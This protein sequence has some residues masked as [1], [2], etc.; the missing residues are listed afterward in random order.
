MKKLVS[1]L[2]AL[3]MLFSL[4]LASAEEYAPYEGHV[5]NYLQPAGWATLTEEYVLMQV[6]TMTDWVYSLSADAGDTTL[7]QV[8]EVSQPLEEGTVQSTAES[9]LEGVSNSYSGIEYTRE[10]KNI[11]DIFTITYTITYSG[12]FFGGVIASSTSGAINIMFI[13]TALSQDDILAQLYTIRD[14]I[15]VK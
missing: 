14:S 11:G 6:S 8:E 12:L 7:Y 2:L 1:L 15:T 3:A 13:N 10:D 9:I 4:T 5:F